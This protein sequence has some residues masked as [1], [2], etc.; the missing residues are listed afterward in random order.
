M[1]KNTNKVEKNT[2]DISFKY[3]KLANLFIYFGAFIFVSGIVIFL[4]PHSYHDK[5]GAFGE[6][7]GGII[8]SIWSL[9]GVFL[10]FSALKTQSKEFKI[11]HEQ[12]ELQRDELKMQRNEL[13]LQRYETELQRKEFERQ[14]QQLVEQNKTLN[15]QKFENTLFHLLRLHNDIVN[16]NEDRD[17]GKKW[18]KTLYMR[19]IG[20]FQRTSEREQDLEKLEIIKKTYNL[21]PK[22][23]EYLDRYFNNLVYCLEFIDL[24]TITNKKFY[25]NLIRAQMTVHEQ[26]FMFYFGIC[27]LTQIKRLIERYNF[28]EELPT[29][30]LIEISHLQY[31]DKSAFD[32]FEDEVDNESK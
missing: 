11:Q 30:E 16:S 5:F 18:S 21:F 23:V 1:A 3:E 13:K 8:G 28:F 17:L 25:V 12:L 2:P 14:T 24:A 15:I 6:F 22:K 31:Y 20:N 29:D 7:F 10:F 26:L 27:S 4:L 9:A 19:F 32:Y